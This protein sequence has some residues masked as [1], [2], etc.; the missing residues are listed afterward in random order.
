MGAVCQ[1]GQGVRIGT[2][3]QVARGLFEAD[4]LFGHFEA[5]FD[6]RL[7][8]AGKDIVHVERGMLRQVDQVGELVGSDKDRLEDGVRRVGVHLE[9]HARAGVEFG[10]GFAGRVPDRDLGQG[11]TKRHAADD[12]AQ[13]FFRDVGG[14]MAADAGGKDGGQVPLA[15]KPLADV[16][17]VEFELLALEGQEA[18]VARSAR[19]KELAIGFADGLDQRKHADG[20]EE[21]PKEGFFVLG[22]TGAA[23]G[24]ARAN[25]G[26][27]AP[28]PEVV[29]IEAA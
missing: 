17:V 11:D 15:G 21:T 1:P 2:G 27:E 12:R 26:Q 13:G 20:M 14:P 5:K 25:G 8:G 29:V 24:L 4:V 22:N 9:P 19:G 6:E 23:G 16:R 10:E 3:S 7:V 28:L 18:P